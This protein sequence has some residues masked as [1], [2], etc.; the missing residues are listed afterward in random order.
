MKKF[1]SVLSALAAL[2]ALAGSAYAL[3]RKFFKKTLVVSGEFE[4]DGETIVMEE[5]EE[6]TEQPTEE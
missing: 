2:A 3:Y 1:L 4:D 6:T 5:T